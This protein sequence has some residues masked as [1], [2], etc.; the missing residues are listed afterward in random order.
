MEKIK[1]TSFFSENVIKTLKTRIAMVALAGSILVT[2]TGCQNRIETKNSNSYEISQGE[3]SVHYSQCDF[4]D[5]DLEKLPESLETLHLTYAFYLQDLSEL[6]RICP[7]LKNLYL[8][9]CPSLESLDFIYEMDNL[10]K[11]SLNDCA[12]IDEEF[13]QYLES[14]GIEHN[15]TESDLNAA[16]EVDRILDEIITDDMSDEDKIQ[17]I[18]VYV[19]DNFKYKLSKAEESNMEPLESM[20]ENKSGVCAS[21]AYMMNVMLRKAG[22]TSYEI[23]SKTHA[24]NL[25]EVDGKYYYLDATNVLQPPKFLTKIILE[26]FNVGFCYMSDPKANSLSA[27]NDYDKIDKVIIPDELIEDINN[28]QDMKNIIEKYGNSVPARL[29]EIIALFAITIGGLSLASNA[30]DNLK[31][32][33]SR[34]RRRR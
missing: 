26:K 2:M 27:M 33:S 12:L 10:E 13:V 1:I 18:T 19:V 22:I 6:P 21:Y 24:W 30:L 31:Y 5:G 15:I 11:I 17:A 32:S 3:T 34:R 23:I 14:R 28:G 4:W 8:D 20:I 25:I 7:N 9:N 16:R 29:I